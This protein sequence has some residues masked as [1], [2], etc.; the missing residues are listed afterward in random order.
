MFLKRLHSEPIGLFPSVE[1]KDGVNFIFGKKDKESDKKDS[2]NG[3]GKS[4]LVDLI[5]FCLLSTLRPDQNPRLSKAKKFMEGHSIVLEFEIG[6]KDYLLKRNPTTPNKEIGFGVIG[7]EVKLYTDTEIKPVLADLMFLNENYSGEYSNRWLRKLVPFFIKKERP[8]KGGEFTDPVK[9]LENGKPMELNIYHLFLM[10]IDNTLA[11]K[12]FDIQENLKE[13]QPLMNGVEKFVQETYGLENIS[14]AHNEIDKI[15]RDI[16]GIETNIASFKLASEYEDAEE[17]ANKLTL[18][19]KDLWYKNYNSRKNIESYKASYRQDVNINVNQIEKLYKEASELLAGQIKK[20]L[21]EAVQF[22]EDLSN[23]RRKFL[24]K[25]IE[26]INVEVKSNAGQITS[27]EEE[28][29]KVFSFLSAKAAIS[30]LS[31]AYL[32]LS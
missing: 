14:T 5:D 8:K 17:R 7:E 18:R 12:N 29:A 13:K 21:N 25:E 20:T 23:S 28:R 9:Y 3:I 19:I 2:L 11:Y 24:S 32:S 22:R 10:G 16:K 30:D 1:F 27:L 15:R 4:L 31:E 26:S 6:G